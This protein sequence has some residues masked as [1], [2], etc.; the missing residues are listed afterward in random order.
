MA[1]QLFE[2][3]LFEVPVRGIGKMYEAGLIDARGDE[4][5]TTC[6]YA[7]ASRVLRVARNVAARMGGRVTRETD[8]GRR[9]TMTRGRAN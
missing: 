7:D 1:K 2:L 8:G 3:R 5:Y 9:R 4:T 6:A